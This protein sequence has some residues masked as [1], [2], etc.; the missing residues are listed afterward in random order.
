MLMH[1][2]DNERKTMNQ[3]KYCKSKGH[4]SIKNYLTGIK[5]ELDLRIL[6]MNLRTKFQLKMSMHDQDYEQKLIDDGM[7][8]GWNDGM[9]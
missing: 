2:Q 8:G 4:N 3:Q 9:G 5:F 1:D 6:M 7:M